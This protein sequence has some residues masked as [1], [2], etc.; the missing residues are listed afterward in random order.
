L[1]TLLGA[2]PAGF[3]RTSE[4]PLPCDAERSLTREIIAAAIEVH[5]AL[6]PGLLESTYQACLCRELNLRD[7]EFRQQVDLPVAYKGIQLD[8]GYRIDLVVQNKVVLELKS[9]EH[10]LPVHEAQLL[11]YLRLTGLRV[12]LLINFKEAVLKD[13]IRR[14]VL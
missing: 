5:R 7:I 2:P 10:I 4:S 9:V 1:R 6:G 14:R 12:G 8:C 11:T 3:R 13:G